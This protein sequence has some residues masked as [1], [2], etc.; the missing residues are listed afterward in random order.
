M[1]FGL[2]DEDWVEPDETESIKCRDC[3]YW[4]ECPCGC[5]YGWCTD[6]RCEF[7]KEDDGCE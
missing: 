3:E 1:S 7:T 5:G 2:R 6:S 4:A